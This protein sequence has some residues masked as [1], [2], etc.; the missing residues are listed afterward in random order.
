MTAIRTDH[1]VL[2]LARE[3]MAAALVGGLVES[4]MLHPAFAEPGETADQALARVKPV[5]G[6]LLESTS[7]DAGSD[8]FVARA[9]A[10]EVKVALFCRAAESDRHATWAKARGVTIFPLPDAI[11][12]MMEWLRA[13]GGHLQVKQPRAG[14]RRGEPTA[15]RLDN[16]ALVFVDEAGVKWNVYDRRGAERRTK[17]EVERHFVNELGEDRCCALSD[18]EMGLV[19]PEA[20][21]GQLSRAH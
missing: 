4:A 13:L 17:A 6:V 2:V 9:R 21:A 20:L 10:R 18:E 12:P 16:G 11:E 1:K 19:S 7:E 5:L 15:T 14:D 3:T 8:L